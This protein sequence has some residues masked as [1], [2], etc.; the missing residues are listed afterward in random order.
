MGFQGLG[1]FAHAILDFACNRKREGPRGV[2][3]AKI[4]DD[5]SIPLI[6]TNHQCDKNVRVRMHAC[7]HAVLTGPRAPRAEPSTTRLRPAR[8]AGPDHL[9]ER[10]LRKAVGVGVGWEQRA[11]IMEKRKVVRGAKQEIITKKRA[12]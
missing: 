9:L 12:K 1:N 3:E 11:C 6:R 2:E 5:E 4:N 8:H 10:A 7:I